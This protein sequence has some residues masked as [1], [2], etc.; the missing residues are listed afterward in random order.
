METHTH[1]HTHTHRDKV[2]AISATPDVVGADNSKMADA[3]YMGLS[4]P[5][6]SFK[7]TYITGHCALNCA[8]QRQ[9]TINSWKFET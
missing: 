6:S 5:V 8:L 7:V 4:L 2:I 3:V 9:L 1:T